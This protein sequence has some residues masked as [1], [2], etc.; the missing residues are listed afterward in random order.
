MN[1][2]W[3]SE[4]LFIEFL[5]FFSSLTNINGELHFNS[6]NDNFFT[7]LVTVTSRTVVVVVFRGWRILRNFFNQQLL[8]RQEVLTSC[9]F[10]YLHPNIA[11]LHSLRIWNIFFLHF[12]CNT[13]FE[14]NAKGWR[15]IIFVNTASWTLHTLGSALKCEYLWHMLKERWVHELHLSYIEESFGKRETFEYKF[16]VCLFARA[17]LQNWKTFLALFSIRFFSLV[18]WHRICGDR[19]AFRQAVTRCWI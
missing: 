18:L 11:L 4:C 1:A 3:A 6:K 13:H 16:R 15:G 17:Q 14:R 7:I 19:S 12:I 2:R 10:F 9:H 5:S 8:T